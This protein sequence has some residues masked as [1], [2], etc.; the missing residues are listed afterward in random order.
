MK[1]QPYARKK[2]KVRTGGKGRYLRPQLVQK[3]ESENDK[4]K[5]KIVDLPIT[6]SD[7]LRGI[8]YVAQLT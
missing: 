7:W 1:A 2:L 8:Y 3:L 4:K 5:R 6:H